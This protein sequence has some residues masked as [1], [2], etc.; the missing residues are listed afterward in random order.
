[1]SGGYGY[2]PDIAIAS[3]YM[4]FGFGWHRGIPLAFVP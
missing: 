4:P 3:D 2:F 1:M